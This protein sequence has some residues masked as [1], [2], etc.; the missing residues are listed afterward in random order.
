M[1]EVNV[2][3][4]SP[5]GYKHSAFLITL[6]SGVQYVF[7]PTGP[8]FGADWPLLERWTRYRDRTFGMVVIRP[9]GSRRDDWAKGIYED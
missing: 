4:P 1:E 5:I 8:Q 2:S 6:R 9:L 7:D 3:I